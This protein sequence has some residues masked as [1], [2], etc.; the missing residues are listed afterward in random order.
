MARTVA[1]I[2]ARLGSTRL[3]GKILQDIGGWTALSHVYWRVRTAV[4]AT[5]IAYPAGDKAL[6][7]PTR[8]LCTYVHDNEHDVLG[9]FQ[10]AAKAY[11]ADTVVR[12]TADCPFVLLSVIKAAVALAEQGAYVLANPLTGWPDGLDVEAF[13]AEMLQRCTSMEHV[14]LGMEPD[15]RIVHAPMLGH[16]RLTL[17]T[18]EDLARLRGIASRVDCTPPFHPTLKELLDAYSG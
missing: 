9:R 18:A 2:Q 5:V 12:I 3:P 7:L 15:V 10:A 13:P 16:V 4:R 11:K 6:Y 14:T 1:I 8:G 17:D